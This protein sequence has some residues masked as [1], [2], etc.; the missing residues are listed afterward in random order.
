MLNAVSARYGVDQVCCAHTGAR[1]HPYDHACLLTAS[2]MLH[3]FAPGHNTS[4]TAQLLLFHIELYTFLVSPL[5]TQVVMDRPHQMVS[6]A[7]TQDI[8]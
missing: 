4:H 8:I 6:N 1:A 2:F 7:M 5:D 3:C